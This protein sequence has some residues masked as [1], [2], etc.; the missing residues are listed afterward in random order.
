MRRI[1]SFVLAGI[2][3]LSALVSAWTGA[4]PVATEEPGN[5]V[6]NGNFLELRDEKPLHW[7]TS[8]DSESVDQTLR[9]ERD[10]EGKPHARLDCTRFEKAGPAAHAMLAQTDQVSL[11]KGKAYEFSCRMRQ[12]H[13]EGRSVSVAIQDT[14]SWTN[15]GLSAQFSVSDVWRDY[16]RVFVATQDV[17][18]SSR[19]Q[20]WFAETGTLG[21]A[22]VRIAEF[23][24]EA[25][26][27]HTTPPGESRNLIA[28]ASFELGAS[29]WSSLGAG[30]GWGDL[31]RLH[32]TVLDGEAA[33]GNSFLRIPLG[34]GRTPTLAFDYYEPVLRR[35]LRPTAANLGWTR[36]EPGATYTLS[37]SLRASRDGV[38]ALLGIRLRNPS[39]GSRTQQKDV[40][41][42]TA[43]QRFELTCKVSQRYAFVFA[44]PNLATDERVDVDLDAVQF[45][46]SGK[47]TDFV[48][49]AGLEWSLEPA[50]AGGIFTEDQ[51]ATLLLRVCNS[52]LSPQTLTIGLQASDF[53]D[54]PAVLPSVPI[55]LTAGAKAETRVVLPGDWRGFYRIQASAK[56]GDRTEQKT[57]RVAIVPQPAADSVCG[58]NHAFASA[59]LIRLAGKAGV[60]WYRDWSLKMQHIEPA[61]G[62]FRWEVSD[63]Q[64]DRVLREG[65]Q[66]L[67]LLPPFPS[68]DWCSE[69][70]AGLTTQGYPG[71][72]I[73]SAFAPKDPADLTNFIEAA[74][75]R[76]RDR[77][78]IW[79]FLN[80]P[81]YTDY[82]LP[83]DPSNKL[84]GRK[85]TAADY[86][87]LLEKAAAAMRRADPGCRV[88]GGIAG[89][90]KHLTQE[91]IEAGILKHVD[92]FNLHMYPA[93]RLPEAFFADMDWLL[94]R[95][96]QGG[97]RK[98]IWV[99]E[100]SYYAADDLPR[101]PF[102]PAPHSWAEERLL[103]SE[104]QCADYTLRF[105]LVMLSRNVERIFI[106]SGA[107]GRV[108][109][110]NFECA[111]F[112]NEGEPRKL[113]AALAVFNKL[114][115]AKP[116]FVGQANLGKSGHCLAFETG[117]SSLLVFW[118][119][120]EQPGP[121]IPFAAPQDAQWIDPMGRVLAKAPDLASSPVYLATSS[122]QAKK[123]LEQVK[124]FR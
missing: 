51:P 116:Q 23:T 108:N 43:W 106:H 69:A 66:V 119:T 27:T 14:K 21:V 114:I 39:G 13:L 63:A 103:D 93:N 96:D 6:A 2:S 59:D 105:F 112:A 91:V 64:I 122:G 54:H 86:V 76:Y 28:N 11:V 107:S 26:F 99:T 52:G 16:R 53:E 44:G 95:M 47:A 20:I 22:G 33:Q 42:T 80:E 19:L 73:R 90:P 120:R 37:C 88:M 72:R 124:E 35:E 3:V 29:G 115:G 65:K 100:F 18:V 7:A 97:G 58:I 70:P 40:V 92:L 36:V 102:V 101:Q 12:D 9:I 4:L 98:P 104:R 109:E 5:L 83:A 74:V 117:A 17:S 32:G 79:E 110:P 89:W 10:A 85:Y 34:N 49:R 24:A 30:I 25:E 84:G 113:F 78:R 31:A 68:A 15:C 55:S 45:E 81:V 56:V 41:L 118:Q 67:P 123:L 1:R 61:K 62:E 38:P 77:I 75:A 8:G 57:L 60:T 50:Q 48:P 46:Q 82:A 121:A 111:L 71:N 94:E 87:A